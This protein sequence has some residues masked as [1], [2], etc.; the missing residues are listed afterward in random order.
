MVHRLLALV[1]VVGC[2]GSLRPPETAKP[3][4]AEVVAA[5]APTQLPATT[6]PT[7]APS[8]PIKPAEQVAIGGTGD[9]PCDGG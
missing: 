1:L 5:P 9:D 8:E 2:G 3:V 4:P 7:E 6:T